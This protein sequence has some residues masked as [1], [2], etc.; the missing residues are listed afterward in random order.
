MSLVSGAVVMRSTTVYA[1][2]SQ[3][4]VVGFLSPGSR[5]AFADRVDAFHDGLRETG[6]IERHN[7][8]VE[9]RWADGRYER[10]QELAAD[11]V[12]RQVNVIAALG[13]LP[14]ATAAKAATQTIPVIFMIASDPV[15]IGL[16][17]S[18]NRPGGN[19]TGLTTMAVELGPKRLEL[20][21]ELVPAAW[22]F[23][24]L[25]NPTIAGSIQSKSLDAAARNLG[26]ELRQLEASSEDELDTAFTTMTGLG[27]KALVIGAD[28]FF[29]SRI[30]QIAR[31]A[32]QRSIAASYQYRD[33]VSGGGLMS[34]GAGGSFVDQY[35]QAGLYTGRI[36]KG[37]QP[38]SLPVLQPAKFELV[39]NARTAN[40]LQVRLPAT[41][42]T[43]ADEVI[44]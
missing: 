7:V 22:H 42:L 6:Y 39:L 40:L 29:N 17:P 28:P 13:G 33:F 9:Y 38:A 4:P 31:L 11:L 44:E 36:L 10:L 26:M 3:L 14:S 37:E 19:L 20:L 25:V 24:V 16:V 41:L 2:E 12:R 23:G 34:Y 5:N 32:L 18:L 30:R 43:R 35:R 27:I 15:G 21:R 8:L 1:Q